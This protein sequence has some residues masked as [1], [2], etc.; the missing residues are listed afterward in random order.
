MDN[1]LFA[2]IALNI[3]VNNTFTYHVPDDLIA[4]IQVGQLVRVPFRTATDVGVV[5]SLSPQNPA[6]TITTKPIEAILDTTIFTHDQLALAE[7]M[8]QTYLAPLGMCLWLLL[9]PNLINPHTADVHKP[10]ALRIQ[11]AEIAISPDDIPHIRRNLGK[12]SRHATF[13]EFLINAHAEGQSVFNIK[14]LIKLPNIARATVNK[15]IEL[16]A[17]T[18][19]GDGQVQLPDDAESRLYEIRGGALDEHILRVLG[20]ETKPMDV[21]WL[22]AQTNATLDDLKRLALAG[23]IHLGEK[24]KGRD[25]LAQLPQPFVP[26]IPPRLTDDQRQVWHAVRHALDEGTYK[27]FLLHGVTG[28]GKTEIYLRAIEHALAKGKSALFLV[29]EIALTA[30]TIQRVLARF[31]SQTDILGE[32]GL[33]VIGLTHGSLR[34][35]DRKAT[36]Q[37]ARKGE[38]RVII[39]TRSAVFS[40]LQNL[41][42]II[43]DEEHD[44]SYKSSPPIPPPYYHARSVA[45][46]RMRQ[47]DG[48]LILGSATPDINT[49]Y[50][51]Q[52]GALDLLNMPNRILGHRHTVLSQ[53]ER[54]HRAPH[55]QP[56]PD[57]PD[58]YISDMPPVHVVDMRNEL[59]AG[60]TDMFSRRLQNAL[61]DTFERDEQAILFLNRR[62]SSTYVFCRDCGYI[63]K[64]PRCDTP[65]THHE[66]Q[67]QLRCHHCGYSQP[68]PQK[69]PN[70]GSSRIKFFGAGT[71]QVEHAF[72]A[73]FPHIS[74]I[75]WDADTATTP[76]AHE[77]ILSRFAKGEAQVLIGTQMIAKG[78]DLPLV[79]LV[80]VMSADTELGLPDFRAG[81]RTFQLLTQVAG[82]AG[83]S[84]LGGQVILQTYQ[85]DHYAIINAQ[86]HDY[87]TFYQQE[88]AYR[89]E[90]GYPP[91]RHLIRILCQSESEARA[92]EE[93]R[94]AGQYLKKLSAE[95]QTPLDLIAPAPCF[96][97]KINRV[98]RWHVLA[99]CIAP[100]HLL[101]G[102]NLRREWSLEID[103]TNIL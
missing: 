86:K 4:H 78:L 7:W 33:S 36:W 54:V 74:T 27:G 73:H 46:F 75:R 28:S 19:L 64:C 82:R 25:H 34:P 71:Q 30:Q 24:P 84:I 1:T 91:F 72:K 94:I 65:M 52:S 69:C 47:A 39:G 95:T 8:H 17:L 53:A 103:P 99:I 18:D 62:G 5:V 26:I 61:K 76:L 98:Y 90:V 32:E 9:P 14:T 100:L 101:N 35:T 51:A 38:V 93:A 11:V 6:P 29:P 40:P 43:L 3:H 92:S 56:A 77:I 88:L 63:A 2:Q 45:E 96:F 12:A 81:E 48:I 66:N 89:R 59:I 79:T 55:Y 42:L 85:P 13:L 80:G 16:G 31:A 58:G 67:T 97:G 22:Y 15:L 41:G 83:R 20:R 21:S 50:R 37:R 57:S 10:P 49:Y 70:C 68:T 60:N 44:H 23:F 87:A 102:I